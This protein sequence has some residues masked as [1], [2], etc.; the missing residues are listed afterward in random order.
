MTIETMVTWNN[1]TPTTADSTAITEY[2][3]TLVANGDTDG[4]ATRTFGPTQYTV[5]RH[6]VDTNAADAW[7]TYITSYNPASAEIIL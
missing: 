4:V 7:I 6:W 3:A 5:V 1:G 2:V